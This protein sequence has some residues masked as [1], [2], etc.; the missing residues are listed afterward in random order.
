MKKPPKEKNLK[1][2]L[3]KSA[4]TIRGEDEASK[5]KDY[6]LPLV[7]FKRLCDVFDDELDKLSKKFKERKKAY[8]LI[9]ADNKIV[10]FFLPFCPKDIEKDN[11]W[12][13]FRNL[14]KN[15]GQ[16]ITS[17][18]R[19]TA[20]HNEELMG[21]IDKI[22]YNSTTSGQRDITDDALINLIESLS[23]KRLG[24]NDVEPDIIGRS[25]EFL[26]SKFAEKSGQ[27]AGEFY[28]PR[29][30][31]VLISKLI[32]LKEGQ[33]IYDPNCG[34]AGLLIK[35]HLELQERLNKKKFLPLKLYGQENIPSTWR[36]SK[37]NIFIH[38]M[39][40]QVALGD[41]MNDPKF[42]EKK[43]LKKFDVVVA[44]PMWNQ[45]ISKSIY[46][47]DRFDR[48]KYGHPPASNADLGWIQH[49]IASTKDNGQIALVLDTGVAT[50]GSSGEDK[51][52]ELLIR[53]KILEEDLIK[54]VILLP[55]NLFYNTA[56]AGLIILLEKNKK[57]KNEIMMIN[58]SKNFTKER[59]K[60]IL[61]INCYS[62]VQKVLKLW[63]TEKDFCRVVKKNEIFVSENNAN[64]LPTRY[65]EKSY[66]F[67]NEELNKM[68]YE[69][70]MNIF[71]RKIVKKFY[72]NK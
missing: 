24:L 69:K 71:I 45:D 31:G 12:S 47:N 3:W 7:F 16:E 40:C 37:M 28:T 19:L 68:Q 17:I 25:Y 62:N 67:K 10:R 52:A 48:F 22:D 60:N 65:I 42:I 59:P 39:D 43:G 56:N 23:V 63:K 4:C 29:E 70:Q 41:T 18:I 38:N 5:F 64:I 20:K 14:K 15:V 11:F 66:G 30:V 21:V 46:E 53:K 36:M 26:I 9:K 57:K 55:E 33:E 34:S 2:W 49:M 44:N 72:N 54:A 61:D 8:N 27:T 58:L 35:C 50:R 51:S 1:Q 13:M 32:E 6:I